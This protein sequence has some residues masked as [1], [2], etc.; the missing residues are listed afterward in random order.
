MKILSWNC[1]CKF[2]E[3]YHL[4]NKFDADIL[5]IQE[6]EDPQQSSNSNY[7]SWAKNYLWVGNKKH[8]GLGV[9]AKSYIK[10]EKLDL[11]VSTYN[12]F[13]PA[14][15]NNTY[16]LIGVWTKNATSIKKSYI[17]Q[18]WNFLLENKKLLNFSQIII[19]GDWNSNSQSDRKRSEGNHTDVV[20]LLKKERVYSAYHKLRKLEHGFEAEPTFYLY[21][22]IEKPYHFDYIF[23]HESWLTEKSLLSICEP[24]T[25]LKYSDHIPLLF[26]SK[27]NFN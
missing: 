11:P 7:R 24:A 26:E 14:L 2:R 21:R 27:F 5:V 15:I 16:P 23:V 20:K 22:N 13:L 19:A 4:L 1:N 3:K 8:Q 17:N 9:F 18:L 10:L 6:C 25:W 12:L